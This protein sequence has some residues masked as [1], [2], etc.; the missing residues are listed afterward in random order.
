VDFLFACLLIR[1]RN[2][3]WPVHVLREAL[4]ALLTGALIPFAA[5]PWGLGRW[6]E[7]S[8]LGTL[9][10]APLALMAGIGEPVRLIAAQLF[11][12]LTLWPLALWAFR[13]SRERM[14]SYGG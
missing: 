8:P 3:E 6:L 14:V 13:A 7:L 10:G 11:W 1:M 12:N 2:L 5:L 9:A 4:N